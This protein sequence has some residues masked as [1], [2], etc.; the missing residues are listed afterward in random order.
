MPDTR[1]R[2]RRRKQKIPR[3]EQEA[4]EQILAQLEQLLEGS[5]NLV[6]NLRTAGF[7]AFLRQLEERTLQLAVQPD[8]WGERV[9]ARLVA[10]IVAGLKGIPAESLNVREIVGISNVVL[11]CFLLELGRRKQHIEIEFAKDPC[12]PDFRFQLG[13]GRPHATHTITSEQLSQLVT[14]AGEELVGLC[15]FG[16]QQS[17]ERIDAELSR[18][19][20]ASKT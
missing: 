9:R 4:A 13:V 5:G 18:G 16:D 15:Y 3:I 19:D 20:A 11:P 12:N 10:A 7:P 8:S 2:D 1:A 14:K 17:R 6:G